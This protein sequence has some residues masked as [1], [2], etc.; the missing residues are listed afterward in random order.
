[1]ARIEQEKLTGRSIRRV[2]DRRFLTGRG[3]Y[4]DDIESPGCLWGHVL[5]SP[6]AHASIERIDVSAAKALAGV[7]GVFVAADLEGLG[8]MPCMAA[9]TPLIVPPRLA[10]A[11]ER[12]RH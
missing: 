10:L 9:V 5:R 2:E 3:R 4:V 7:K 8:P 12:V 11:K 1:M 6:H